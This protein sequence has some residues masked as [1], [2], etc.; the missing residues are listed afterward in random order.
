MHRLPCKS[1]GQEEYI[2]TPGECIHADLCGPMSISLGKA[3]YFMLLKDRRIGYRWVYFLKCKNDALQFFKVFCNEVETT[4]GH[5]VKRS[6]VPTEAWSF[7]TPTSKLFWVVKAFICTHPPHIVP[8]K[9]AGLRGRTGLSSNLLEPCY[10]Q[11]ISQD[12]YGQKLCI[13]LYTHS[14]GPS[15]P[16]VRTS[17]RRM[18]CGTTGSLA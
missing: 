16:T 7:A 12:S 14:T 5:K 11:G 4:T 10:M 6:C 15:L 1:N 2:Y 18:K 3:K 9:T 8:S 13:Q 17:S